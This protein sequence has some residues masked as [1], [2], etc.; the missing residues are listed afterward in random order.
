ML[1]EHNY[2]TNCPSR[3]FRHVP[4]LM[5]IKI[6]IFLSFL[7]TYFVNQNFGD[8]IRSHQLH[9]AQKLVGVLH[10]K[11]LHQTRVIKYSAKFKKRS[12]R[13]RGERSQPHKNRGFYTINTLQQKRIMRQRENLS[14]LAAT[15]E[16][17]LSYV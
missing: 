8:V 3:R 7:P 15:Y 2:G 13:P 10:V 17:H 6:F 12:G 5:F 16:F 14:A 1:I 11:C 4:F 9:P